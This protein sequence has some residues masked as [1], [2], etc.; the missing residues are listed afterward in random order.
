MNKT[1]LIAKIAE[2]A[3]ISKVDAKKALEATIES[4]KGALKAGEKVAVPGIATLSV[5]VRP[6]RK[7]KNPAT[8]AVINIPA[9]KV[10]K[11]K[12]GTELEA[13]VK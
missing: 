10:I 6:A 4:V 3:G 13:A 12:A 8:G 5:A 1:E 11:F 9:K 7:G 2:T